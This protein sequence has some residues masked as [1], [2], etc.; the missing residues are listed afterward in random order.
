[1]NTLIVALAAYVAALESRAPLADILTARASV[2]AAAWQ[3]HADALRA[4]GSG[5]RARDMKILA[6]RFAASAILEPTA[7]D[8]RRALEA[9]RAHEAEQAETLAAI[10]GR[11]SAHEVREGADGS[12]GFYRRMPDA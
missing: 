7:D 10:A 2:N 3:A 8:A 1:M 9:E 6:C 5:Y 11:A 12:I 4:Q